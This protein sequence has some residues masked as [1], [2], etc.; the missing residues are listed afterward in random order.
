MILCPAK[1]FWIDKTTPG[2]SGCFVDKPTAAMSDSNAR[3]GKRTS[4]D[5]DE[6]TRKKAKK[7]DLDDTYN[8]YLAHMYEQ[9]RP[10]NGFRAQEPSPDSP[11]AGMKRRETSAKQAAKAEDSPSNPFNGKPHSQKYFSILQTRRDLPVSKQRYVHPVAHRYRSVNII[12]TRCQTRVP[13]QISLDPDPR[14]CR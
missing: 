9:D 10:R 14:L 12:L 13:R 5:A 11:L 7:E 6:A 4:A 3:S 1:I 8:P 2:G